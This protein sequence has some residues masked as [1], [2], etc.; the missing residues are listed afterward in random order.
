[1][2]IAHHLVEE[3]GDKLKE[4]QRPGAKLVVGIDGYPGVGKSTLLDALVARYSD[5]LGL[6]RDDFCIDRE[7][8]RAR[9]ASQADRVELFTAGLIDQER[10]RAFVAAYRSTATHRTELTYNSV[11]GKVDVEKVFDCTKP[12]LL[13]E[14]VFLFHPELSDELFDRR[15]WLK[16]DRS[17]LDARRIA[18]E[19]SRWGEEYVSEDHPDSYFAHALEAFQRYEERYR[20]EVRADLVVCVDEDA[21]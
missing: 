20:P 14:G 5:V 19:K 10:L 8:F 3:V 9:F 1:M 18:R 16:G 12:I 2:S 6:A 17:A 4:W 13:I 15:I 21:A 11:T 7:V